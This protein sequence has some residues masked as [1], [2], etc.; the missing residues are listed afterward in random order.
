[1][2]RGCLSAEVVVLVGKSVTSQSEVRTATLTNHLRDKERWV[3]EARFEY[4]ERPK[5]RVGTLP[6]S[7]LAVLMLPSWSSTISHT[8]GLGVGQAAA[9]KLL[10]LGQGRYTGQEHLVN[11]GSLGIPESGLIAAWGDFNADQLLDAFLLSSDQRTVS[12]YLWNR[13][14][15]K[16]Q[17]LVPATIR[18]QADF[19]IANVVPG[20]YNYDG[21]LDL[22]LMGQKDPGAWWGS[23]DTLQ[24][25]VYLQQDDGSFSQSPFSLSQLFCPSVDTVAVQVHP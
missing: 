12:T 20:D 11:A 23:D 3:R 9:W 8:G 21:R 24:M 25:H 16:F 22:L 2:M 15:Y 6:A 14:A 1:M 4:Q 13:A 17:Q 7:L 5:M 18:T 10:D 19:V